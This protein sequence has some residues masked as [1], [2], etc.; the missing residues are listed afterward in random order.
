[1]GLTTPSVQRSCGITEPAYGHLFADMVFPQGGAFPMRPL[2]EPRVETELAFVLKTDLSGPD[3]TAQAAMAAVGHVAPALEIVD[4]RFRLKDEETGAARGTF[5]AVADNT[6]SAFIVLGDQQFDPA[7]VDR[8]WASAILYRGGVAETSGVAGMVL[9]DPA[10]SLA[11]LANT[12]HRRGDA[13]KAGQIVMSGC[14]ITPFPAAGGDSFLA[15][16]GPLGT[17]SIAFR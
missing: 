10:Q 9:G 8:R 5:D 7:A 14:F 16:F 15:D 13:L 17:V 2:F 4:M 6:S 11:W 12:L 3:C 1:V